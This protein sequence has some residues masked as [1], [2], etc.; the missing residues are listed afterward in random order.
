MPRPPPDAA[1]NLA[2]DHRSRRVT[3]K[4]SGRNRRTDRMPIDKT[5]EVNPQRRVNTLVVMNTS[6]AFQR[7][8]VDTNGPPARTDGRNGMRPT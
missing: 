8:M 7:R 5:G 4:T 3:A 6:C 2:G 1:I